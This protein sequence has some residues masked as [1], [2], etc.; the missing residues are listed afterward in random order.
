M[1]KMCC[2]V[3]FTGLSFINNYYSPRNEVAGHI[4]LITSLPVFALIFSNCMLKGEATN[5][6]FIVFDS[7]RLRLEPTIYDTGDERASG[8]DGFSYFIF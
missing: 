7:T 8:V 2:F 1:I 6:N 4:I 3:I 5:I